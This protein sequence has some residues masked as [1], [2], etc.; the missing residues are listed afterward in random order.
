MLKSK[1]IHHGNW[2]NLKGSTAEVYDFRQKIIRWVCAEYVQ[3]CHKRQVCGA[4][5]MV[6]SFYSFLTRGLEP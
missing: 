6:K 4:L 1:V 5:S 3:N 2:N